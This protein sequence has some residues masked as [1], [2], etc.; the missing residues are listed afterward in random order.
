MMGQ[1]A[2]PSSNRSSRNAIQLLT[3]D[4]EKVS[5]IFDQYRKLKDSASNEEKRALVMQACNELSVHAQIE[6]EIFYPAMSAMQDAKDLLDEAKVEHTSIKT[7]V[8]DLELMS[9]GDELYDAKFTVLAEYVMHH[10]KEEQD[11]IFPMAKKSGMD[12][13]RLGEE[14]TQRKQVLAAQYEIEMEQEQPDEAPHARK[15]KR[16]RSASANHKSAHH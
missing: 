15:T 5:K 4:H 14:L 16:T 6:E 7:L 1:Q 11:E 9:P 12:L 8:T 13:D 3:A 2:Q 10:V